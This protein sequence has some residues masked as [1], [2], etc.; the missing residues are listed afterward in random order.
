MSTFEYHEIVNDLSKLTGKHFSRMKKIDEGIYRLKIGDFELLCQPGIRIHLTRY[1]EKTELTDKFVEKITKELN[2]ARVISIKQINEDRLISI[3]FEAEGELVFE[4][5]GEGNII[6]VKNRKTVCAY[7]YEKWSDR[8]IKAGVE[9]RYPKSGTTKTLELGDKYII[10]AMMKLP[11]GKEYAL[12][13]LARTEI[14]EKTPAN[15]LSAQQIANISAEIEKMVKTPKPRVYIQNEGTIDFSLTDLGKYSNFAQKPG[16]LSLSEAADEY[17]ANFKA[18][19]PKTEK[20]KIRLEKQ[21]VHK[22]ELSEEE[23]TYRTIGDK[24]Y[25]S[26]EGIEQAIALAKT[27]KFE[28]LEKKGAKINKKERT[29]E[30]E[31]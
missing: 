15:Q 19:N 21:Q 2:N 24:I 14:N 4:M 25:E 29:I 6:L 17:Y 20:L 12:E 22:N 27:G 18:P 31:L 9:Y 23:K 26:Y 3:S 28:E 11:L 1:I 8:E 5:F 7:R 16:C 10:V 30:I 13:V